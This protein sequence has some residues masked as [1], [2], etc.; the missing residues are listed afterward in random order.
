M[1]IPWIGHDKAALATA[2]FEPILPSNDAR[3]GAASDTDVGVVLLRAINV[4]GERI[5]HSH[6]IKLRS[7]LVVLRCPSFAAVGRDAAAAVIRV[8]DAIWVRRINPES[9]VIAVTRGQE[10][11]IFSTIDRSKESGVYKVNCVGGLR[12]SIN[13]AEIPGALTKPAIVIR[14]R[15]MLPGI[16]RAVEPAFLGFDDCIDAIGIGSRNR[17]ADFAQDSAR[18]TIALETFLR[19]AVIFRTVKSAARAAAGE[20][21]WL[22]SRLP[23]RREHDVRIMRIENN[24]DPAS[25]FVF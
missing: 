11:E 5:V 10:S 18:K 21:P 14:A 3:V 16:I 24:V 17:D 4:V 15:P 6:V 22:P 20:K 2:C 12:V 23:K 7:R 13:F 8:C 9:V 19:H 25:V 1:P